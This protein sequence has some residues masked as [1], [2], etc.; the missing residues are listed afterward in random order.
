MSIDKMST[1]EEGVITHSDMIDV[2]NKYLEWLKDKYANGTFTDEETEGIENISRLMASVLGEEKEE[3]EEEEEEDEDFGIE[4]VTDENT[5]KF[6]EDL[7]AKIKQAHN[8]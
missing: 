8:P 4:Q 3:E 1:I 5:I 7:Y 2:N 6:L